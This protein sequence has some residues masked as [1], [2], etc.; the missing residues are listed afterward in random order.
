LSPAAFRTR[1]SSIFPSIKGDS[2]ACLILPTG[3]TGWR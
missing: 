3:A 2:L 1:S